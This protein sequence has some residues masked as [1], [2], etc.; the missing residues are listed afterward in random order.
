MDDI[1]FKIFKLK[2]ILASPASDRLHRV[3]YPS[4]QN[5][6]L[7]PKNR[8]SFRILDLEYQATLPLIEAEI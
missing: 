4:Q 5:K 8:G 3:P 7:V 6:K 1:S 2:T